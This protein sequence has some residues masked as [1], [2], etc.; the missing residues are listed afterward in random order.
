MTVLDYFQNKKKKA[1][2]VSKDVS[3][4]DVCTEGFDEYS[5]N[6]I[7]K[8]IVLNIKKVHQK[9]VKTFSS[10]RTNN[11]I[12]LVLYNITGLLQLQI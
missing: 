4:S 8:F 2:I 5:D 1:K 11:G 7:M 3:L 10:G 12:L 9:S 6:T